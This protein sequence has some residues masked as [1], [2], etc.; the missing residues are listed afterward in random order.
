[1][2]IEQREIYKEII[3]AIEEID[4]YMSDIKD[5]IDDN[6]ARDFSHCESY[7][8]RERDCVKTLTNALDDQNMRARFLVGVAIKI[9]EN[10]EKEDSELLG[11]LERLS[12]EL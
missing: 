12:E 4:T 5:L 9:V 10:F 1:M 3:S 8:D 2:K 7:I 11:I 6:N